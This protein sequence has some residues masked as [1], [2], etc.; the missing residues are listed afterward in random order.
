MEPH[1]KR[2]R[3]KKE[4][5]RKKDI[6]NNNAVIYILMDVTCNIWSDQFENRTHKTDI[7]NEKMLKKKKYTATFDGCRLD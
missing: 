2:E 3:G 6:R 4:K 5:K 1:P 7:P